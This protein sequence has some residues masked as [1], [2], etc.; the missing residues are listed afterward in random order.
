[1]QELKEIE[2]GRLK[3]KLP[4]FFLTCI[5]KRRQYENKK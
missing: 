4:K 3:N 2:N 1:M 5:L